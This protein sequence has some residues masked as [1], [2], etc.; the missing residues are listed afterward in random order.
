MTDQNQ[1]NRQGRPKNPEKAIAIM[2]AA[3]ELFF[4][5]GFQST[6]M[7]KVAKKAGVSKQTVYSHFAN[8]D[9][10]FKACI[11]KT[12][13]SYGFAGDAPALDELPIEQALF[14][15]AKQIVDLLFDP[16]VLSTH[17]LVMA[18][19][20]SQP[21]V[22]KLYYES[23]PEQTL[24]SI[25]QF[26]KNQTDAGKLMIPDDKLD[27]ATGQLLNNALGVFHLDLLLGIRETIEE[28]QLEAHLHC[29][30]EDFLRLYGKIWVAKAA[31][32]RI[33]WIGA[34]ESQALM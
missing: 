33:M 20:V 2:Q 6:S 23:G 22:A 7:D 5:L 30:V 32:W 25:R 28:E 12:V 8:K 14:A 29:V 16:C 18:E 11:N 4:D 10:L 1:Q 26:L 21:H 15:M 3:G 13:L 27:Y 34:C 17:R 31:K 24:A 9:A 19:T